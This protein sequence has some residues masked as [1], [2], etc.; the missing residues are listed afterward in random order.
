MGQNKAKIRNNGTMLGAFCSEELSSKTC[1]VYANF[2]N[3]NET[4]DYSVCDNKSK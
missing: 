1:R 2:S 3:S 4:G